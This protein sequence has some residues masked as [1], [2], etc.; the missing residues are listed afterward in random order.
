MVI[1]MDL[2]IKRIELKRIDTSRFLS[3]KEMKN[4][5]V[6]ISL[7]NKIKA[8]E[9]IEDEYVVLVTFHVDYSGL[10]YLTADINV[11]LSENYGEKA[12]SEWKKSGKLP[13]DVLDNVMRAIFSGPI[14]DIM[15]IARIMHLPPPVPIQVV[16]SKRPGGDKSSTSNIGVM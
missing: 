12:F 2:P 15:F 6:K 13:D 3:S 1:F 11:F 8:F 7:S 16:T 5:K 9:K 4:L 10:G 14:I